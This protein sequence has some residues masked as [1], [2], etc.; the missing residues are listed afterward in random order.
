MRSSWLGWSRGFD[1]NGTISYLSYLK[2]IKSLLESPTFKFG[3][4][5]LIAEVNI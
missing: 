4:I 1:V 5:T 2:H 3:A